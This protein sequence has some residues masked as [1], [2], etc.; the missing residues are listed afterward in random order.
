MCLCI[1]GCYYHAWPWGFSSPLACLWTNTYSLYPSAVVILTDF[2][3]ALALLLITSSHQVLIPLI[4]KELNRAWWLCS[5]PHKLEFKS[6]LHLV[7]WLCAL[8]QTLH[9]F[10]L[11]LSFPWNR[12]RM[13]A[14]PVSELTSGKNGLMTCKCILKVRLWHHC[15][16]IKEDIQSSWN[17]F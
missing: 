5:W 9:L 17:G 10:R 4:G 16:A 2:F 15:C 1:A 13:F 3:L 8:G 12:M 7:T 11:P 6:Q 14:I